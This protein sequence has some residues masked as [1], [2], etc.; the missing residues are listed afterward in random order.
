MKKNGVCEQCEGGQKE[1]YAKDIITENCLKCDGAGIN[2][3]VICKGYSDFAK[4]TGFNRDTRTVTME[5][6]KCEGKGK[7]HLYGIGVATTDGQNR[8]IK[9]LYSDCNYCGPDGREWEAPP[10]PELKKGWEEKTD[11]DTGKVFYHHEDPAIKDVSEKPLAEKA[12]RNGIIKRNVIEVGLGNPTK[13]TFT[14]KATRRRLAPEELIPNFAERF[15]ALSPR[16]K[17][18]YELHHQRIAEGRRLTE[19]DIPKLY[20]DTAEEVMA[21]RWLIEG[22]RTPVLL[23]DLMDK[24]VDAQ[25]RDRRLR[26]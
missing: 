1:S 9:K 4:V 26:R 21:K 18:L 13:I 15:A 23:A 14:L 11:R 8:K 17:E 7:K 6:P 19:A 22:D 25:V 12:P 16:E 10:K 5:C 24:I 20:T 2:T 3:T